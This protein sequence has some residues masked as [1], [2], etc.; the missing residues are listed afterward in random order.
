MNYKVTKTN[1]VANSDDFKKE[2]GCELFTIEGEFYIEGADSQK[3]ADSLMAAHNPVDTHA[4]NSA[5][6]AA[7]LDKLGISADEAKLLLS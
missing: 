2:S 5:T 7:L 1:P 3:H 4:I 6:K